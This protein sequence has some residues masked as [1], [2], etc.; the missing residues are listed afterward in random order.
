MLGTQDRQF[1][2]S[3][4][5]RDLAPDAFVR[6][7]SAQRAKTLTRDD[8]PDREHPGHRT[9]RSARRGGRMRSPLHGPFLEQTPSPNKGY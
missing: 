5:G 7:G 6:D 8:D 3:P 2:G 4:G 9:P 1:R